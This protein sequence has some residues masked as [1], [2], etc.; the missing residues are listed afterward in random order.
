MLW[1]R[2]SQTKVYI[3]GSNIQRKLK[4]RRHLLD[5]TIGYTVTKQKYKKMGNISFLQISAY[6]C[7]GITE[8]SLGQFHNSCIK[9]YK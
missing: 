6:Q 2:S 4:R 7:Y 3:T 5:Q 1:D 8:A 9:N